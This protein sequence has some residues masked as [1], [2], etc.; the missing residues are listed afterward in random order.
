[1]F[2]PLTS[3]DPATVSRRFDELD[4]C[5]VDVV[6]RRREQPADDLISTIADGLPDDDVLAMIG[7]LLFAGHETVTGMLGN[8]LVALAAHPDQRELLRSTPS[9]VPNAVEEL[10]RYDSPAQV[11]GRQAIRDVTIGDGTI[12]AG[13]NIALMIGAANHDKRR[14]PDADTLR[15]D[16]PDPKPLSFGFGAHHCLGAALARTELRFALP[17]LLARLRDY[18]VD[19]DRIT[20]KRSLALRGPT[21]LPITIG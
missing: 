19:P 14:W 16:R 12:T 1:L 13:E 10:L 2:D 18:T 20:W 6:A 15:L 5:F 8:A 3:F 11:S 21:Q 17:P 4:D 9:I 7:F